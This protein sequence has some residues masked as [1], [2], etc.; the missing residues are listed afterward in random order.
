MI[1]NKM[2]TLNISFDDLEFEALLKL[3]GKLTWKEFFKELINQ[4]NEEIVQ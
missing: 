4:N 2:R 3:K 1:D